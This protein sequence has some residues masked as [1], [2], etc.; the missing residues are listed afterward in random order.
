M[1]KKIE[2]Q[3]R[4]AARKGRVR[5]APNEGIEAYRDESDELLRVVGYGGALITD[6]SDFSD[7]TIRATQDEKLEA[8]W[9]KIEER[10]HVDV[11]GTDNI[12]A[13]LRLIHAPKGHA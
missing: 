6:L 11:R 12:L 4:E 5:V 8:M 10:Y 1:K 2:D 9:R 7:F 3:I 13:A